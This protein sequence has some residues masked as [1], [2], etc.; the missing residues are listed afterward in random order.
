MVTAMRYRIICSTEW[1]SD[2]LYSEDKNQAHLIFNMAVASKMFDYVSLEES[3]E[4]YSLKREWVA[5][6]ET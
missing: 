5:T 6:D 1:G 3:S 4:K 2:Y